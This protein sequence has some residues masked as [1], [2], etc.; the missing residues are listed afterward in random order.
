MSQLLLYYQRP[1]PATWVFLSSFLLL[2]LY[3]VFHRFFSVR[4][5]DIILL[6][7]LAPGLMMVYEGRR[8][9]IEETTIVATTGELVNA[10]RNSSRTGSTGE[11]R[12]SNFWDDSLPK[13]ILFP[14]ANLSFVASAGNSGGPLQTAD[15]VQTAD[16]TG[17]KTR[18]SGL[19]DDGSNQQDAYPREPVPQFNPSWKPRA[20]EFYGFVV[21]LVACAFLMIRMLVDP[22]LVR[23]PLLL[24]NLSIGGLSFIG[25]SLFLFLMANVATSTPREQAE[26][27]PSLGPGYVL[28]NMLP[29]LPTTPEGSSVGNEDGVAGGPVSPWLPNVTRILSILSN[30]AIVAGIIGIGYWH[31][32]NINTGIGCAVLYLILPYTA[33]MT[34]NVEHTVPA[35]FLVAALLAY[36]QPVASGALLGTAAGLVYYPFF[37]L[38]LWISFYWHRG[39]AK[40][41]TGIGIGVGVLIIM[42]FFSGSSFSDSFQTMFGLWSPRMKGLEGIWATDYGLAAEFRLPILVGCILLAGSFVFWP[43]RKTLATLLCGSAASMIA[44]QFWHGFGGGLYMAWFLPFTLLTMFRPNLDDRIAE[45]VLR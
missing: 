25:I 28:L 7:L 34:G 13:N 44:V 37:L 42:L 30:L 5:L 3:F 38:P 32:G 39:L 4:N 26:R 33:Q 20:I 21:L 15:L 35:A 16:E 14:K 27:G 17:G 12:Q 1:E 2:S 18:A 43:P 22:A 11:K 41:L 23:R 36:R 40:F 29:S 31:F 45:N 19:G 24:P 9:R 10:S 8:Q 6:L